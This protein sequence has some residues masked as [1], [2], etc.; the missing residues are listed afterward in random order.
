[1]Q[2]RHDEIRAAGGEVLVVSFSPPDRVAA[3]LRRVGFH[4]VVRRQVDETPAFASIAAL[5]LSPVLIDRLRPVLR[6]WVMT[7]T[8]QA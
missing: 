3:F 4:A 5:G 7:P 2:R 1:M 6:V 8:L